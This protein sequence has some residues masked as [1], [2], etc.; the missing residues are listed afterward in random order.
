[1]DDLFC[2]SCLLSVYMTL[3]LL[4]STS[5]GIGSANSQVELDSTL[6]LTPSTPSSPHSP[7]P[8]PSTD[9]LEI[10]PTNH[11]PPQ[12][13][14]VPVATPHRPIIAS[15]TTSASTS[16]LAQRRWRKRI[17][18]AGSF[19]MPRIMAK[20]KSRWAHMTSVAEV[21]GMHVVM[22]VD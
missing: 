19:V 3:P 21:S 14:A 8:P 15:S 5:T 4:S 7:L 18:W 17:S 2:K 13:T 22:F 12:P 9:S 1:M 20:K 6:T 16:S 11:P 10:T